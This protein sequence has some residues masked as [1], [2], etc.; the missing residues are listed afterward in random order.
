HRISSQKLTRCVKILLMGVGVALLTFT[1]S[2]YRCLT[3]GTVL[4]GHGDRFRP[5]RPFHMY[6]YEHLSRLKSS[7]DHSI[8]RRG[9]YVKDLSY[10]YATSPFVLINFLFVWLSEVIFNSNPSDITYWASNQLI[11]AF[12][13]CIATYIVAFYFF[14]YIKL[15]KHIVFLASMLYAAST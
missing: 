1:P 8:G 5:M 15:K 13:K 9:A 3:D 2:L 12:F 10:Y 4:R 6:L 14:N 11:V 7:Y